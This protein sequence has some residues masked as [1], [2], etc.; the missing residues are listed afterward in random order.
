[1]NT[2]FDSLHVFLLAFHTESS[3]L[4][5]AE[6]QNDGRTDDNSMKSNDDDI[7]VHDDNITLQDDDIY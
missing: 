4:V 6:P 3:N 5:I 2:H 1:M 7:N